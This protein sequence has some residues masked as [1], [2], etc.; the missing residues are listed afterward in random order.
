MIRKL[1]SLFLVIQFILP[2]IALAQNKKEKNRAKPQ[3]E[4]E[5]KK[6]GQF[7]VITDFESDSNLRVCREDNGVLDENFKTKGGST[8]IYVPESIAQSGKKASRIIDSVLLIEIKKKAEEKLKALD[9]IFKLPETAETQEL[10]EDVRELKSMILESN[11]SP[12]HQ[13]RTIL[14]VY[15]DIEDEIVKENPEYKALICKYEVWK[16]RREVIAKVAK[17]TGK[18]LTGLI[19]ASTI[20]TG[21]AFM[22][23]FSIAMMGPI[24]VALGVAEI[25]AGGFQMFGAFSNWD[26]VRAGKIAKQL[27]NFDKELSAYIKLLQKEPT[28][29]KQIILELQAVQLSE[30]DKKELKDLKKLKNKRIKDVVNGSL[31]VVLGGMSVWGG[32]L[33][34]K[35]FKDFTSDQDA[36]ISNDGGV[37]PFGGGSGGNDGGGFPT[38]DGG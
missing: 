6:C 1:L 32:H 27:L 16:H 34:N 21:V 14:S 17:I 13:I 37:D 19:L 23:V 38:D 20:A 29:N 5:S 7:T 4:Y 28:K 2:S 15:P 18:I 24:F 3:Y 9:E 8:V 11:K 26:D 10:K 30:T 31:K 33:L 12:I 36:V 35:R 22:G 25:G